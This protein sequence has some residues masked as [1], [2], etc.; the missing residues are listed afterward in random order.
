[1]T[2]RRGEPNHRLAATMRTAGMSNKGLGRR[3]REL[4]ERRGKPVRADH[5]QVGRWLDGSVRRPNPD[6]CRL[7]GRALAEKLGRPVALDEIGYGDLPSNPADAGIETTA[8]LDSDVT[9]LGQL[10][11]AEQFDSHT[12][13]SLI[14]VPEAWSGLLVRWLM[15]ADA[16][17]PT[18][19]DHGRVSEWDVEAVR[20]ACAMFAGYDYK[21]G[22]GRPKALVARFLDTEVLPRVRRASV[23][24]ATGNLYFREVAALTRL[25]GWTAYDTGAHGLAQRYFNI[26]FRLA[27]AAGDKALCAR[28]LAGMSHQ[29][30]FLGHH[31][32]AVDLAAGAHRGAVGYATPTTLALAKA[33]EARAHASLGRE[34]ETT[35]ALV[36]AEQW[37]N[38]RNEADDPAW[39]HYFDAAELHAEFAHCFRD[40][41]RPDRAGEH[42]AIS[43]R[44]SKTFY[45][46]SLSFCRTVLATSHLQNSDLEQALAVAKD[47]VDVAARLKSR[48][49]L[50]YLDDFRAR[51]AKGY[52]GDA[53][54]VEFDD[55]ASTTLQ[56]EGVPATGT[57]RIA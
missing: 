55:Y 22:G 29:A 42:A 54:C 21:F 8:D 31:Q 3:V 9:A 46:R 15:D 52:G 41:S 39:V 2:A 49:V 57:A 6:T 53:L 34:A 38:Q 11:Q 18:G 50:S 35:A 43:I 47:V 13:G 27:R 12:A 33:M 24:T 19:E 25:A 10:A 26:A 56:S 48:R 44:E 7:V 40:L 37:H 45:V 30:N 36:A 16:P 51:A 17:A 14:V 4:S 32:W 23:S 28:I 1:M 20:D 5:V